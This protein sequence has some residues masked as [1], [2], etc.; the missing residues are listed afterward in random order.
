M[1]KKEPLTKKDLLKLATIA[2]I[3]V[4]PLLLGVYVMEQDTRIWKDWNCEKM[5]EFAASPEHN[6][7]SEQEHLQ[8]HKDMQKCIDE[9]QNHT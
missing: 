4:V 5:L 9:P 2:G 7:L 6:K 1:V 3:V 8:L